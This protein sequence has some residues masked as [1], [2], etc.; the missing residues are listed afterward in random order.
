LAEIAYNL[1]QNFGISNFWF[2]QTTVNGPATINLSKYFEPW[3]YW[4]VN[5]G[6]LRFDIVKFCCIWIDL[7]YLKP[8]N[9][10]TSL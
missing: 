7:W 9:Y 6:P 8:T 5:A 10:I 1:Q 4:A 3:I 2:Y